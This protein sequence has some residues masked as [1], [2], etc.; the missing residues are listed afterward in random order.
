[1]LSAAAGSAVLAFFTWWAITRAGGDAGGD[2]DLRSADTIPTATTLLPGSTVPQ[3][4]PAVAPGSQ[5]AASP[6]ATV[7]PV[8]H[9]WRLSTAEIDPR[10]AELDIKIVVVKAD[11]LV[12]YDT[13]SGE[14]ASM[15]QIRHEG[16]VSPTEP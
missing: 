4:E 9:E 14:R 1:L 2:G 10:A 13:R 6:T 15:H 3:P 12:E 7:A 8:S 11:E 16:R 5:A